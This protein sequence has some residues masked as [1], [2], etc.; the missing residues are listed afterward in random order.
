[1]KKQLSWLMAAMMAM[2][3]V[4]CANQ[5]GPA[6]QAVAGAESA[7]N[8][9]RDT[10]QKY[11][12]DQ[13][14]A[15]DTQLASLKDSLGK[16][17]YKTVVAGAPGLN[18]AINSLKDATAAKAAEAEAAM[19]KAKEAWGS[20]STDVPKMVAALQSRVDML[21]K[22]HHLPSGV[23]KDSLASA[24][25]GLDSMKSAWADASAAATSGDFSTAMAKAT[26]VKDQATAMMQS[27]GMS[28]G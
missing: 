27:L 5:K 8:A 12:P 4:G 23:T 26:A 10:A 18:A 7:L 28:S 22:S 24:K 20:M 19:A 1:M 6:E 2:L 9:I 25:T 21:S 13:L 14:A 17:D 11:V 16:G 15:V 3:I